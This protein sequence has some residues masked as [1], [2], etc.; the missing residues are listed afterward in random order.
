VNFNAVFVQAGQAS[1]LTSETSAL[2]TASVS[3]VATFFHFFDTFWLAAYV[4]ESRFFAKR[5]L[6]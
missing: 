6:C 5:L 2:V 1:T 4:D 3:F